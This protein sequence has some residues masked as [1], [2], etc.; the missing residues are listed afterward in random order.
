MAT[1]V[2]FAEIMIMGIIIFTRLLSTLTK[3][4]PAS[5]QRP[6]QLSSDVKRMEYPNFNTCGCRC[7]SIGVDMNTF[8][9][10]VM[11]YVWG[12]KIKNSIM[13]PYDCETALATVHQVGSSEIVKGVQGHITYT[14]LARSA[15]FNF[16]FLG[17]TLLCLGGSYRGIG[18]LFLLLSAVSCAAWHTIYSLRYREIRAAYEVI[19]KGESMC[20]TELLRGEMISRQTGITTACTRPPTRRLACKSIAWGGG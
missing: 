13:S 5:D 6:R 2:I 14:R 16:F 19:E 12:N 17:V 20:V 7:I 9:F 10:G 15:L 4:R 8:S 3:A 18:G 11:D 1:T